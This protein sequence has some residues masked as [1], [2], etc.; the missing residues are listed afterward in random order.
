MPQSKLIALPQRQSYV[1]LVIVLLLIVFAGKFVVQHALPY[2][3]FDKEAFGRYWN[4]K[5]PLIGH[6][7][8]G[9]VALFIGPFQFW[10][11]FR[12]RYLTTHR[13]MGRIYL[14]AIVT[15]TVSATYLAWTSGIRVN[16]SWA[17]GLQCLA[18]VW[19]TSAAMAFLS[20]MRG[21]IQQHRE[22]M[23][24]SYV[25][26]FAFVTFRFLNDSPFVISLMQKF[27]ERGPA[28][29]W[30]CWT[31]PLFITEIVLSWKKK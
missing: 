15:G 5:W 4:F 1:R 3:G 10:K 18:F 7:S 21:R 6:I 9:I 20:V 30:F 16:F 31:I 2:F 11:A 27:D 12:N 13:W 14:A 24:R 17:L 23:I 29:I 25:I 26:T 19:I 22:W 8:G 28:V